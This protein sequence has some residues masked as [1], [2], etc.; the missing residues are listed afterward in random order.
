MPVRRQ[1][2][3]TRTRATPETF[4]VQQTGQEQHEVPGGPADLG[5]TVIEHQ[6]AGPRDLDDR[7]A[8]TLAACDL[9]HYARGASSRAADVEES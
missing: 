6:L 3:C 4:I 2:P 7:E 5:G 9:G 8:P 1:S